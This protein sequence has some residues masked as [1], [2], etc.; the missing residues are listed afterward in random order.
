MLSTC[1]SL[2]ALC[3]VASVSPRQAIVTRIPGD[4]GVPLP[5]RVLW[6]HASQADSARKQKQPDPHVSDDGAEL[7]EGNTDQR[8]K[9]LVPGAADAASV[10]H[11]GT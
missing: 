2:V 1:V 9:A 11:C 10:P 8:R 7:K 6:V 4:A 5:A 3:S